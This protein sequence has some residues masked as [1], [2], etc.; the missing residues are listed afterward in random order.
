MCQLIFL[1]SLGSF[2]Y[3][4]IYGSEMKMSCINGE[5]CGAQKLNCCSNLHGCSTRRGA[6]RLI[7]FSEQNKRFFSSV[8]RIMHK[9]EM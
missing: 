1:I 4:R 5:T 6:L 8:P 9:K 7:S 3:K 2:K